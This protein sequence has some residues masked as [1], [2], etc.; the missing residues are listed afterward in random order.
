M[1]IRVIIRLLLLSVCIVYG[2]GAEPVPGRWPAEKAQAWYDTQPWP[3]GLNYI[4]ANAISYTE[5]WMPYCFDAAFIDKD[6]A[7]MEDVGFNCARVVLPF[8]VWE[9]DPDA[10][11]ERL[12]TFLSLCSK[13]GIKV[14]PTLFDDCV[15]GPILD[16][17]YGQQPE[18]VVGWYANGWTPSPGRSM[19]G[20]S[21]N[22]ESA[23]IL[24]KRYHF[25]V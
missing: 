1:K 17:V 19:V 15:F 7:L 4:P 22:L 23:G 14:M 8:V 20:G 2:A 12:T 11:K 13:R 24:C 9:H 21:R 25:H 5:M 6:L 10:F 3:C 16:P 18:V